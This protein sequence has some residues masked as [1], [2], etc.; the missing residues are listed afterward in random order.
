[1][2]PDYGHP[3]RLIYHTV[4]SLTAVA[5]G[6]WLTCWCWARSIP[7]LQRGSRGHWSDIVLVL[8]LMVLWFFVWIIW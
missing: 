7:A 6:L 4:L 1:M 3:V 8:G 2:G 5:A